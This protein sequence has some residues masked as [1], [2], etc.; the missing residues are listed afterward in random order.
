MPTKEAPK[1]FSTPTI[2]ALPRSVGRMPT[3]TPGVDR[4]T[5]PAMV[6]A[7][8]SKPFTPEKVSPMPRATLTV[9]GGA[10]TPLPLASS[11]SQLASQQD[12]STARDRD[13]PA[14]P[15]SPPP[16]PPPG[17]VRSGGLATHGVGGP[18]DLRGDGGQA[19]LELDSPSKRAAEAAQKRREA[20]D[21]RV[22]TRKRREEEERDKYILVSKRHRRPTEKALEGKEHDQPSRKR[23]NRTRSAAALPVKKAKRPKFWNRVYLW[24]SE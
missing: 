2:L 1:T 21:K 10:S 3:S 22:A 23:A 24:V 14:S 19:S 13:G 7:A 20:I 12:L 16:K 9:Q 18:D 11:A 15:A 4:A 6:G 8:P 17:S 5:T